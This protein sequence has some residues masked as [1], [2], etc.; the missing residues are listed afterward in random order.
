[1]SQVLG[2]Y[3]GD[4][5]P[6][7]YYDLLFNVGPCS[8]HD[9]PPPCS[10]PAGNTPTWQMRAPYYRISM[11]KI[12]KCQAAA[13]EQDY[14]LTNALSLR[15]VGYK[16]KAKSQESSN[17][18]CMS[19]RDLLNDASIADFS[20]T[21]GSRVPDMSAALINGRTPLVFHIYVSI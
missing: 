9:L 6:K 7:K 18:D 13:H 17:F 20:K 15:V 11:S 10:N 21:Y 12:K 1:M 2:G 4:A 5:Y 3:R 19:G 16:H 14:Q 8:Q